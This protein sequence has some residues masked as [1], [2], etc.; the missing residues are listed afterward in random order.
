MKISDI[1]DQIN[2]ESEN[3]KVSELQSYRSK[4]HLKRP[5]T[6]KI[7]SKST[8]FEEY[9][10]HDGGRTELQFNIGIE[11]YNNETYLRHGVAFS[12]ETNKTLPSVELL[13]DKVQRFNYYVRDNGSTLTGYQ[14]WHWQNNTRSIEHAVDQIGV[15]LVKNKTF[16]FVGKLVHESE[17]DVTKILNDFDQLYPLY[18]YVE[19]GEY[20]TES[21][22]TFEFKPGFSKKLIRSNATSFEK[23]IDIN[24]RHNEIQ[25]SVCEALQLKYPECG[26]QDEY[27]VSQ[28]AQV[29]VAVQ[30]SNEYWF[31]EIKVA[32]TARAAI[33]EALGQLIEYTHWPSNNRAGKLIVVG[34][35]KATAPEIAYLNKLRQRYKIPLYYQRY[36]L[37]KRRFDRQI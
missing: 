7:F 3:Y 25:Y 26:I 31:Y 2:L 11:Y 4:L 17:I 16:V 24:L 30:F 1:A 35:A 18:C 19:S 21:N 22:E 28:G 9:A 33:R 12:F 27:K 10:F 14:M 5:R 20:L 15:N 13:I 29:D 8:I 6:Y 34:E 32:P 37:N 36:D 23:Q